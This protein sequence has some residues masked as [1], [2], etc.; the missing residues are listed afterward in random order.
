M[1]QWPPEL[2][3]LEESN[4]GLNPLKKK[5]FNPKKGCLPKSFFG[6]KKP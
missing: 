1:E 2:A 5:G 3:L 4:Q 6:R